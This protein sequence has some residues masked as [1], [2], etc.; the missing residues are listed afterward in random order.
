MK[1]RSNKT[2]PKTPA[3]SPIDLES[4]LT[5]YIY[6]LIKINNKVKLIKNSNE[7]L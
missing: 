6:L 1:K 3:I 5:R 7:N 2:Q 4:P